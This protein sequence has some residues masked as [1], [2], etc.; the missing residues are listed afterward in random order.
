VLK[1]DLLPKHFGIA[2]TNKRILIIGVILLV[3][4][5]VGFWLKYKAIGAEI[6]NVQEAIA[7]VQPIA[8]EVRELEAKISEK[9][10]WLDPIKAKIDFVRDADKTGD[11]YFDRFHSINKYIWEGARMSSFSITGAGSQGLGMPGARGIGGGPPMGGGMPPP[12]MPGAP[13]MGSMGPGMS[14]PGTPGLGAAQP[15]GGTASTVQFTVEVHGDAGVGR[16]LLNLLRCP[17]LTNITYSGVPGGRSIT[18]SGAG[19]VTTATAGQRGL[20]MPGPGGSLGAAMLESMGP[21]GMSPGMPGAAGSLGGAVM[22]Q[23]VGV[24]PGSPNEP[25]TLQISATL[26]EPI[27]TPTPP[28]GG[29]AAGGMGMG[30]MMG[31]GGMPPGLGMAGAG[32]VPG[33]AGGAGPTAGGRGPGVGAIKAGE[34]SAEE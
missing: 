1:I 15:T 2:R 25:I 17:D 30:G 16:F 18:A 7:E 14:M 27:T 6:A 4:V 20:G 31:P 21:G 26:T 8:D 5:G 33:A 19:A 24:E 13:P 23:G 12:P 3:V 32:G 22:P 9:Q 34:L 11:K 10:G 28:G 29:A